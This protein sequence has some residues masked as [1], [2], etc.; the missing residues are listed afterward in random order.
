MTTHSRVADLTLPTPSERP[1]GRGRRQNTM[2]RKII[3]FSVAAA[4][5]G[6]SADVATARGGG[7]GGGHG[8]GFGGGHMGG[9][10]SDF[11]GGGGGFGGGHI[12]GLGGGHIG[13]LGGSFGS[14]LGGP[15]FD[16]LP[17]AGLPN[18]SMAVNPGHFA[19]P[20]ALVG[21]HGLAGDH[22]PAVGARLNMHNR[23]R[24]RTRD[25]TGDCF[26]VADDPY[27]CESGSYCP[28]STP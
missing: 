24:D 27:Y 22:P 8:G 1:M 7:G 5:S 23:G 14:H 13:G 3:I 9:I 25:F 20:S 16:H 28:C 12:G 17:V 21:D 26:I 15:A 2:L 18:D 11:V 6:A 19:S 10:G 4:L